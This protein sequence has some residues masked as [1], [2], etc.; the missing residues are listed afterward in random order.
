MQRGGHGGKGQQQREG[1][2]KHLQQD[3]HDAR[4]HVHADHERGRERQEQSRA[5]SDLSVA[6]RAAACGRD[7]G[8]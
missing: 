6:E 4:E 7:G 8:E 2:V 1:G 5:Q 3:R